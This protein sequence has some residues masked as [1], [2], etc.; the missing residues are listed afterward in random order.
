MVTVSLGVKPEPLIVS[1]VLGT[2]AVLPSVICGA[3]TL[4]VCDAE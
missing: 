1:E 4:K 3:T 2:T